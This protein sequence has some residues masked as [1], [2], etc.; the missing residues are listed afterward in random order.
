MNVANMNWRDVEAAAA[1]DPRCILPIGSTE[2]HAQLSLCVDMILAEKVSRDAAEPLNIPV[3]PV[4][5]YGLA[6]YFNAYPGTICLR[7]ETLMAV[8]R[9]VVA[10]L[11]RSGFRQILIVNGHGGNNPVGALAQELMAEYGDISVKFHNWWNAPGTWAKAQSID[12]TGSHANWMENF[13]WTRLAHAPAPE[14]EK[15]MVDMA[16]MKASP[17]D[18]AR[19]VLGDGSFGGLWQRPDDEMQAIWDIGVAE[20]REALEGP[21]PDLSD[22]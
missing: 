19:S 22:G 20:T 10:S 3:F 6:P 12:K 2:Q 13:P 14:G 1:R 18:I 15:P 7:V 5:P 11:R 4:M 21:W 16:L 8:V 9:D 17:P